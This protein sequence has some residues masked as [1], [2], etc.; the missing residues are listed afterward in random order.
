MT[1]KKIKPWSEV[2]KGKK[3]VALRHLHARRPQSA[4]L[5]ASSALSIGS[6]TGQ[7]RLARDAGLVS[8][9]HIE[10]ALEAQRQAELS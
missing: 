3:P 6:A 9:D 5:R 10:I 4:G 2:Q 8:S 1:S 7:L